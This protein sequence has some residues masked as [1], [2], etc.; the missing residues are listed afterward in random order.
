VKK[1]M[2]KSVRT[3]MGGQLAYLLNLV[4]SMTMRLQE[5]VEKSGETKDYKII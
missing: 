1:E 2:L 5:V 4:S 3:R